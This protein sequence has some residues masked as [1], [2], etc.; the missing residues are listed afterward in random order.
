MQLVDSKQKKLTVGKIIE[1]DASNSPGQ[2]PVEMAKAAVAR[3]STYPGS[4]T[5][6]YG[7]TF[8]VVLVSQKN[9]NAAMVFTANA[10]IAPNVPINYMQLFDALQKTGVTKIATVVSEPETIA[11]LQQLSQKYAITMSQSQQNSFKVT[12]TLGAAQASGLTMG[13][14]T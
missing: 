13:S 8:F 9:P 6:R 14:T 3:M 4:K 7:N 11:A 2:Q 5:F 12:V 1:I 10:D